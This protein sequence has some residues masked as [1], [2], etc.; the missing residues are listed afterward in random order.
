MKIL[1]DS[2][3]GGVLPQFCILEEFFQE[4]APNNNNGITLRQREKSEIF[5]AMF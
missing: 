1:K 5:F 4:K 3:D 2:N